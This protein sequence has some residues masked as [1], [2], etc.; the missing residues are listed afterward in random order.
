MSD[1]LLLFVRKMEGHVGIEPTSSRGE[2]P[3]AETSTA[4]PHLESVLAPL[5]HRLAESNSKPTTT[6]EC[7]LVTVPVAS[8]E[9]AESMWVEHIPALG[10]GPV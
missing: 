3:D 2:G 5:R 4:M 6:R 8:T 10:R 7:P 1:C 9:L